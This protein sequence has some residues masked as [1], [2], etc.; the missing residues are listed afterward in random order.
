MSETNLQ[1]ENGKPLVETLNDLWEEARNMLLERTDEQDQELLQEIRHRGEFETDVN[2][3]VQ[4]FYAFWEE[5]LRLFNNLTDADRETLL[6]DARGRG[7]AEACFADALQELRQ[8]K[9]PP[10]PPT[11]TAP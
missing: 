2:R 5:N 3:I 9:N 1:P 8:R 11:G 10:H 7:Q 4:E 6:R